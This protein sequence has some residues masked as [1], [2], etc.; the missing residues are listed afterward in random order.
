MNTVNETVQEIDKEWG[1]PFKRLANRKFIAISIIIIALLLAAIS[2]FQATRFNAHV[3]IN[4]TNVSGLTAD[5]AIKKLESSVLKNQIYIG[6]QKIFDEKD[7]KAGFTNNDL[8]GVKK[9]LKK[10]WTFFPSSKP[11]QYILIPAKPDPYRT[12]TMKQQVEEKLIFMN[13]SL[14][15]PQDAEVHL[16][17]GKIIISKSN[18][19]KQYDTA[20][21]LQDY[22]KQEY[23]SE[24]HLNPVY[25]QPIKVDSPIVKKEGK[26]LQDLLQ[27]TVDYKVQD[28]VY[29]LKAKDLIKDASVSKDMKVT[30]NADDIK[31]KIAEINSSQSTLN[32]NFTFK[33]HSGS[34]I[35]VKGQGYGWALNV[36][37]ETMRIQEAFEK[38]EKS[39]LASNI[40]GVG[41]S[42]E[43]IGYETTTNNGIGDTYAEVSIAEQRIWIYKNGQLVLTTNVVTGRHNTHED[44]SPGVWYILFKRSPSTLVG[45][46]VGNPNYSVKVA[47]WAPFTNSGQGFHDASWRKNW[48]ST[49][50]L[51]AGSGGCVN[52]PPSNMKT[53]YDNLSRYEPVVIY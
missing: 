25:I 11:K 30:I 6:Q 53:V 24:I 1:N 48:S 33:T 50:Y 44:T 31:N 37:K 20:Q 23:N 28:N 49:A 40:Y 42:N 41:W 22:Q 5:Q 26:M 43:G 17:Q 36:E 14:K 4:D 16:V 39:I 45:S 8:P 2:Y 47:Y 9:L 12:Q 38:G 18:N 46:E 10:Q 35:S 21:L 3:T 27:R 34:V 51:T 15:A 7:T 19:G 29:T 32:K 13:K 52:T